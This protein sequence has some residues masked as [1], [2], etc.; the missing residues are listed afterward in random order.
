MEKICGIYS[1]TNLTNNKRYIGQSVDIYARFG[2]HKSA[3][4]NNRHGN[5]HLQNAW[6]TYGED[7]FAFEILYIC[8]TNV[9]DKAEQDYIKLFDTMNPECG[10]NKESGGHE[11]KC[12]S[13]ESKNL[14]SEKHKGKRLTDEH[15]SKIGKS[16][17]GREF[18][19][20]TRSKISQALTGIK[21]SSETKKKVSDSRIGEKSWCN[22]QIYCIELD[23]FFYN[24]K[25]AE[26]KYGFNASSIISH[27]KGRYS[28]SGRHPVTGVKLHW[29][30]IDEIKITA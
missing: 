6:N 25:A 24:I 29:V 15:K 7:N 10:Y 27:L 13:Q 26:I 14:I 18:S 28:Y 5:K 1:I 16:G 30:Y 21:R 8:D 20:E 12:L 11:N 2:N 22:K 4:R 3:L 23:E 9:I 19:D 17:Q